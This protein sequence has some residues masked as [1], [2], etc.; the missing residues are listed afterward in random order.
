MTAEF[1]PLAEEPGGP[2]FLNQFRGLMEY[3]RTTGREALSRESIE[4]T[5]QLVILA[6]WAASHFLANSPLADKNNALL[7]WI[8]S[9]DK[10]ELAKNVTIRVLPEDV[11]VQMGNITN[12][13]AGR[14]AHCYG[15]TDQHIVK[16]FAN[17]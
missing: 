9:R 10:F 14:S 8:I 15:G 16:T 6:E 4:Q 12:Y 17:Q 1:R 11:D 7:Q 13:L 3:L 2:T 5:T